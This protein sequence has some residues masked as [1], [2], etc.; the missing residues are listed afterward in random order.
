[1]GANDSAGR[2]DLD[3]IYAELEESVH[4]ALKTGPC[5]CGRTVPAEV[6]PISPLLREY[7]PSI[8]Y[9]RVSCSTR[10]RRCGHEEVMNAVASLHS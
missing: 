1:V 8:C 5:A 7:D 6:D 4:R 2:R 9:Y 10:C 3:R